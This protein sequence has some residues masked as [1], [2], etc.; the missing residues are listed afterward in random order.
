MAGI[1]AA[2]GG[3]GQGITGISQNARLYGYSML[4]DAAEKSAAGKWG[5]ASLFQYKHALATLLDQ[6]VKI[7]NLSMGEGEASAAISSGDPNWASYVET[8]NESMAQFLSQYI[9]EGR[10]FLI[11]KSAGNEGLDAKDDIF[12]GITD[13]TVRSHILVVGASSHTA[14]PYSNVVWSDS[15]TVSRVNLYAPGASILSTLPGG[16]CGEL[17]GTSMAAPMVT[18]LCSLIWGANPNLSSQQVISILMASR[19]ANWHQAEEMP[20]YMELLNVGEPVPIPDAPFC[21]NLAQ[22]EEAAIYLGEE[23]QLGTVMGVIYSGEAGSHTAV[24]V[25]PEMLILSSKPEETYSSDS[26]VSLGGLL[27]APAVSDLI[28]LEEDENGTATGTHSLPHYTSLV[29]PGDYRL[30][31]TAPG[32]E[33]LVQ[34]FSVQA[35]EVVVLDFCLQPEGQSIQN[36]LNSL[37]SFTLK[38]DGQAETYW[39]ESTA[40]GSTSTSVW[41]ESHTVRQYGTDSMTSQGEGHITDTTTWQADGST[42]VNEFAYQ[43]QYGDGILSHTATLPFPGSSYRELSPGDYLDLNLPDSSCIT[44]IRRTADES[45][46]VIYDLTLDAASV[47]EENAHILNHVLHDN[48]QINWTANQE[49][50]FDPGFDQVSLRVTLDSQG[51]LLSIQADYVVNA[52]VQDVFKAKGTTIFSFSSPPVDLTEGGGLWL[53]QNSDNPYLL[54]FG[55]DGSLTYYASVTRESDYYTTYFQEGDTLWLN[56]VNLDGSGVTSIPYQLVQDSQDKDLITLTVEEGQAPQDRALLDGM[57]YIMAGQ[58]RRM[59]FTS[60]QLETIRASLSV[61]TDRQVD[62]QQSAPYYW[63]AGERWLIQVDFYEN[64]NY[65][66][67]AAF[68]AV[69]GE[70]CSNI[71]MYAG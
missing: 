34:D 41:Q 7:I 43:F 47:T 14:N 70:M 35:G 9:Q 1:I 39:P 33:T 32:Y 49:Y 8:F 25:T 71:Y 63:E 21:V 12:S 27:N 2:A 36:A 55:S 52:A 66:A 4:S 30:Q 45:G 19:T 38:I 64:G 57:E 28:F 44:E 23:A 26:L 16:G 62:I 48:L 20:G 5:Y 53:Q 11:I 24:P 61:P 67:G 51:A 17:S 3:N 69:T 18:G 6:G 56:L 65:A 10:D 50:R 42:Q 31:V 15:N 29:P 60:G 40:A 37:V 68:D 59:G 58:Y 22:S 46:T 54:M 13:E